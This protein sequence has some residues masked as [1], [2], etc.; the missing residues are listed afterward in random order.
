MKIAFLYPKGR[1]LRLKYLRNG[2]SPTEYFYGAIELEA[3]RHKVILFDIDPNN[4]K[5]PLQIFVD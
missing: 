1:L 4:S 2:L 3:N 5:S